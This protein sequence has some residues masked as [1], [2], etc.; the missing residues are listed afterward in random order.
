MTVLPS[1]ADVARHVC[2]DFTIDRSAH[3]AIDWDLG[4]DALPRYVY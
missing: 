4:A 2:S 3:V 1:T